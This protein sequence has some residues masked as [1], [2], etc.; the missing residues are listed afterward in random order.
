MQLSKYK[1]KV[2]CSISGDL[3]YR[4]QDGDP[5]YMEFADKYRGSGL[6][7]IGVSMD[8]EGWKV[9]KPFLTEKKL[10][11]PVVIADKTLTKHY[12]GLDDAR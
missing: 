1:G 4:L 2:F 12:G 11:Y 5:W 10:N 3:V 7:V 9:G 6:A 8:A